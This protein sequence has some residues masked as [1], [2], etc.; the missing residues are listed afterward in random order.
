MSK[1]YLLNATSSSRKIVI[2]N[3]YS[4]IRFKIRIL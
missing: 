1:I 2:L 4:V 3:I